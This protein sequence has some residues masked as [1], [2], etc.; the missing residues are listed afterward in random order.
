MPDLT[1]AA[2]AALDA[3][4]E[5]YAAET[6]MLCEAFG[7]PAEYARNVAAMLATCVPEGA[8]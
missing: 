8:L 2:Q 6:E 1:A 3:V 4:D 7:V 5:V